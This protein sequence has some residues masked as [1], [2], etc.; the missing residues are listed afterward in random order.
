MAGRSE[1]K[2][3][4]G[5]DGCGTLEMKIGE[6][7]VGPTEGPYT[8]VLLRTSRGDIECRHYPAGTGTRA[9][10]FVGGAGGGFDTP[11]RGWL[12]P[13]VCEELPMHGVTALRVR[14]RHAADLAES[15]LDV[16]AGLH[17]L[18]SRGAR[19]AAL[20][21]HSFGGA[22][23]IQAAAV[24]PLVRGVA[25]LS[26]QSYGADP[27][28]RLSPRCSVLLMHGTDDE[29][30]SPDCSRFVYDVAGEPKRLV[31][32]PGARHGLDEAADE[33]YSGVLDW[34][35]ATLPPVDPVG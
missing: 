33:V 31:L 6:F 16:L 3:R 19:A 34:I 23:V 26:T 4:H 22:V 17:F 5:A 27:A 35:L 9:A 28:S 32:L 21:G 8:P 11:V 12:Y 29:V 7:T 24:S 25:P 2:G 20:V 10:L 14:Y 13:R 18:E 15:T 30:L 1:P